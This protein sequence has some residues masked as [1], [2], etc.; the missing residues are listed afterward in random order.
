MA[1]RIFRLT[2][3]LAQPAFFNWTSRFLSQY[4]K[5]DVIGAR[6]GLLPSTMESGSSRIET[7]WFTS[8]SLPT[9]EEVGRIPTG[10]SRLSVEDCVVVM[11]Q[12]A[13]AASSAIGMTTEQRQRLQSTFASLA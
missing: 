13:Q 9:A 10:L 3:D 8:P 4:A 2:G 12:G 5:A 11:A 6:I 1:D 7:P